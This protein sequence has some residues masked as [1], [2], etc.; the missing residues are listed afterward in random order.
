MYIICVARAE[1]LFLMAILSWNLDIHKIELRINQTEA[2]K[3][4]C[5]SETS[6]GRNI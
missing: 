3:K 6:Q 4:S 2:C 1:E 5:Y